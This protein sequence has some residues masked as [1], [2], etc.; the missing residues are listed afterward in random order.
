[1]DHSVAHFDSGRKAIENESTRLGL[2]DR[3]DPLTGL[4]AKKV[5]E[6]AQTGI[7][8]PAQI[9][10]LAMEQLGIC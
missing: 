5:F 4:V 2:K 6:I 8:D 10:R 3:D 7:E 1:M 9:S